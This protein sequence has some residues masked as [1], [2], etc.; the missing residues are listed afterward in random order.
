MG[1]ARDGP[2]ADGLE[3]VA[4]LADSISERHGRLCLF[5]VLVLVFLAIVVLAVVVRRSVICRATT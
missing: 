1:Q 2:G 5:F 4:R 3:T